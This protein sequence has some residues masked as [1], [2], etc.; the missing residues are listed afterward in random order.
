MFEQKIS[1]AGVASAE[2]L[3][4]FDIQAQHQDAFRRISDIL[5][6]HS[7]ELATIYMDDF[8]QAAGFTIDAAARQDQIA[9]SAKYTEN[10]FTP[11]I[12]ASWIQRVEKVAMVQYR[13]G[14][15]AHMHLGALNRSHRRS[16]EL[17]FEAAE[18]LREGKYLVEQFMRVA[19]L[20]CEIMST[21]VQ[22]HRDV[23][24]NEKMAE[25]ARNFESSI[26]AIVASAGEQSASARK[27]ARA[28]SDASG[29][30]LE[31][32]NEVAAASLQSTSA[33]A[34]AARMSGG[35]N[36]AID[37]IDGQIKSAFESF[38]ELAE[39]ADETVSSARQLTEHEKSIERVVKL[40]RDIADQTSILALNALIEAAGAGEAGA[41]FAV[42][43]NEMKALASQT[44][45]AT[46]DISSQLDGIGEASQKS[47][48]AHTLMQ[49][50]FGQLRDTAGNLRRSLSEQAASVTTIASCIDETAQSIE[51]STKAI[52][53]ISHR[54]ESVANDIDEVTGNVAELD[55]RLSDLGSS[56]TSFLADLRR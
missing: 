53:E 37:L 42:V 46:R 27:K 21:T 56:A 7:L 28:V 26:A 32:S 34:E 29:S 18:D 1:V 3:A 35:L 39:T 5:R 41:G 48:T 31:L 6:P 33:M 47:V 11:P 8:L 40:I 13:L 38:S 10:K 22:Y 14:T 49:D 24:F 52:T 55:G 51:S 20:E 54:A 9:K 17:I 45:K 23:A 36:S 43:A 12:D 25:N 15:A 2:R 4:S 19:A 16:A 44:E 50:K 30:L